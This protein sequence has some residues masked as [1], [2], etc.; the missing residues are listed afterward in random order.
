MLRSR[1]ALALVLA[2]CTVLPG[3]VAVAAGAAGGAGV[4]YVMGE[5]EAELEATPAQ[6][7]QAGLKALKD[8]DITVLS[9]GSTGIDGRIEAR[10]S[11]DK[12][13]S[14]EVERKDDRRSKI[15]IR[16]GTWG[17]EEVSRMI[18]ERVKAR[19]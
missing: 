18:H 8:L 11:L 3:C 4:A 2:L 1:A 16:V 14:I 17:D 19:L 12:K 9:S 7:V 6:V 13:V 15:R 5:F 10:T